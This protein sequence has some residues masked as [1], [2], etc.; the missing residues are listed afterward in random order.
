MI[1]VNRGPEPNNLKTARISHLSRLRNLGYTPK[2]EDIHG[3]EIV[4]ESLWKAQH[5]KCCY[6]EHRI[7]KSYNDVEHYRP[8]ANADR[9]PGC[10]LKH[11][12]WWL[13]YT[14]EN[15]LFACP[16][17]NRSHKRSFFPLANGS[18]SLQEET[19]PPSN[20]V[21]LLIDPSSS[22]NPVEHIMFVFENQGWWAKERNRSIEGQKSIQIYGLNHQDLRELRKDH[23]ETILTPQVNAIN[24]AIRDNDLVA[25]KKEYQRALDML[26]PKNTF[27]C[28]NY[29]V[30]SQEINNLENISDLIQLSWPFPHQ[31]G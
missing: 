2:S 22:I 30:F 26:T 8:K 15:L 4:A 3:Y 16:S 14:W 18:I 5:H 11:G 13:A 28:F 29:S 1:K 17:C 10:S 20:E 25:L 27:V 12:Y 24:I 7:V 23:Y 6:C 21:P 9:S 19:P 31:I